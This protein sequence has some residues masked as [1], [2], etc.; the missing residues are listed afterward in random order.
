[1][2]NAIRIFLS[3]STKDLSAHRT[4][5]AKVLR[6]KGCQVVFQ[7]EL[8]AGPGTLLEKLKDGIEQCDAF[9][10]LV[11][12]AYGNGPPLDAVTKDF[13][14]LLPKRVT[15]ASYTQWEYFF[16]KASSK[17]CYVFFVEGEHDTKLDPDGLQ[18]AFRALLRKENKDA[19]RFSDIEKL[20]LEVALL[21]L[22]TNEPAPWIAN[23][24]PPSRLHH[25][26]EHLFGR[27]EEI[28]T[29]DAA[30]ADPKIHILSIVA[31]GGVGK[32]SLVVEC[33]AR[34]AAAGWKG[35]ER[36]LDW[37]FYSQ[38]TRE[39]GAASADTFIS[40]ALEF[41]GGEEGKNLANSPASLWDKGSK[42]AQL[43]AERRTLLVLDG[44]EPL[45]HPPGPLAGQLKDPAL[46]VLLKGLAQRNPG[47]CI[48]T[49][50]ERIADLAPYNNTTAPE[51]KL[52]LL[53]DKA[54]AALL[55]QTGVC[56]AGAAKIQPDNS[57]LQLASREV[58][59][60]AL[61]LRLL[62]NYLTLISPTREGDV[63]RRHEIKFAD[64]DLEYKTNPED[65]DKSYGHAFK[66]IAAYVKWFKSEG[67]KGVR[68][69]AILR[70]LG[71]FDRPADAGC[72]A[73]LRKPPAI[74]DL[75]EPLVNLTEAQW[76]ISIARLEECGL[77][78]KIHTD[79]LG[80]RNYE[81][82][83]SLDAHPLIREYFAKHLSENNPDG[84]RAAHRRLYEYLK[85][86]TI[87]PA[88]EDLQSLYTLYQAMHHGCHA[89]EHEKT[90]NEMYRQRVHA[91]YHQYPG[92]DYKLFSTDLAALSNFFK[93]RWTQPV[94]GL[95]VKDKC[96]ILDEVAVDLRGVGRIPE[97]IECGQLALKLAISH[98]NWKDAAKY[99]GRSSRMSLCLGRINQSIQFARKS[100]KYADKCQNPG[101]R[102]GRRTTLANSLHQANRIKDAK[103]IFKEAEK[104]QR[105]NDPARP[106]LC[107]FPGFRYCDFLL[108]EGNID[109]VIIR[110]SE[111]LKWARASKNKID[112]AR[113]RLTLGRACLL[114]TL[115][116]TFTSR[117]MKYLNDT[118]KAL[119]QALESL[120]ANAFKDQYASGLLSHA[121]MQIL[122]KNTNDAREDLDEAW[123]I[124]E[125]GSM[126]LL[127]ADIQLYRA[128]LF[129][130]EKNY[131]W[132]SPKDDLT[133]ARKLI[134][135]CGYWRRKK[136]LEKA[137]KAIFGKIQKSIPMQ[138]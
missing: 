20:K 14:K 24:F 124:A 6:R 41:F 93:V 130:R 77:I 29:L 26:A 62:G 73:A 123:Q 56:L 25:G 90:L 119:N 76:N 4:A 113:D 74:S 68:P 131:P 50:R 36:F 87:Q 7:E 30:A 95:K 121:W 129:F 97:A 5:I 72:L 57:E 34:Q 64:A 46:A 128:R 47:L 82:G 117:R 109:K 54:G 66:T 60:H 114:K 116:A 106:Y 32:T 112:I 88:L 92:S 86:S 13:K 12:Q 65:A 49:T 31:W 18:E 101:H 134:E 94:K 11:G 45:Q 84:W 10:G 108:D 61:T 85:D 118:K 132:K 9:V 58:G 48:V 103:V 16:A 135:Q 37:S 69:L 98:K 52:E 107:S 99:A 55:Y 40:A 80:T 126:R 2:P 71:L 79:K 120:K 1:M 22:G 78:S 100:V 21:P 67:E 51:C 33:M 81:L 111:T 75:T 15:R 42:L 70:L 38:G 17:P 63:L 138:V 89:G 43:V 102:S 28:A 59:G 53:S 8:N 105:E 115:R 83:I 127:M 39:Q 91:F 23:P 133:A 3:A 96:F 44:I 137:E 110:L 122:K 125:R 19:P 104:I 27:E 136:E 35:F